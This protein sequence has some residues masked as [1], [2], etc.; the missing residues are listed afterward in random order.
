MSRGDLIIR[1]GYLDDGHIW[2]VIVD[3]DRD[4]DPIILWNSG[5]I[6]EE[7]MHLVRLAS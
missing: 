5:V 1:T 4:D 3:F 6:E 2:G 7:Y